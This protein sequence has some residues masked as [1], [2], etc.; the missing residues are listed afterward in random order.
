MSL[1]LKL[2]LADRDQIKSHNNSLFLLKKGCKSNHTRINISHLT[3][4]TIFELIEQLIVVS[5]EKKPQLLD[6]LCTGVEL[7]DFSSVTWPCPSVKGF[8]LDDVDPGD[9]SSQASKVINAQPS[10]SEKK[11]EKGNKLVVRKH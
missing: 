1:V 4:L 6:L 11:Q 5:H 8:R 7:L 9:S 3:V 10:T 2:A